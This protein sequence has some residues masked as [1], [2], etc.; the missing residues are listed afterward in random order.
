M[1]RLWYS[2][3]FG[4]VAM[5]SELSTDLHFDKINGNHVLRSGIDVSM[6]PSSIRVSVTVETSY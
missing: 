5:K 6:D 4:D 2:K 3:P 1:E